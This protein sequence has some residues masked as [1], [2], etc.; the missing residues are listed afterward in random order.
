[1]RVACYL[2]PQCHP[3]NIDHHCLP[4]RSVPRAK[5][6]RS[7][8]SAQ[9]DP[10]QNRFV[11]AATTPSCPIDA[12]E[13]I[14]RFLIHVLP[15]GSS[16]PSLSSRTAGVSRFLK[17]Y[18]P[19][20][21]PRILP[22]RVLPCRPGR[23]R[24]RSTAGRRRRVGKSRQKADFPCAAFVHSDRGIVAVRFESAALSLAGHVVFA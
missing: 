21:H 24:C 5:R 16:H 3:R 23:R 9:F 7:S 22:L 15:D 2:L 8:C 4:N 6:L 14:R 12:D 17:S 1:M 20:Y 11:T 10:I 18:H 19:K 13:F